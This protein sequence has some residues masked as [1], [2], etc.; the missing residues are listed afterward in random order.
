[1]EEP[2]ETTF[3]KVDNSAFYSTFVYPRLNVE[4][5]EIRLLR[6]D[7]HGLDKHELVSNISLHNP[8]AFSAL[9]YV[10]GPPTR[11]SQISVSGKLFN[12]F[13][14]L[15]AAIADA[16]TCWHRAFPGSELFLWT[17]QV[18]INQNDDNERSQQVSKMRDV[19]SNAEHTLIWLPASIDVEYEFQHWSDCKQ[20]LLQQRSKLHATS[21]FVRKTTAPSGSIQPEKPSSQSVKD[22]VMAV[23]EIYSLG[24][25]E[26][27][28]R[29]WVFQEFVVSESAMFMMKPFLVPW[30][31]VFEL[32]ELYYKS[33]DTFSQWRY[34]V[35]ERLNEEETGIRSHIVSKGLYPYCTSSCDFCYILYDM[36]T[37]YH[38]G[39]WDDTLNLPETY[40]DILTAFAG[41]YLGFI[42]VF[43]DK[44]TL[45]SRLPLS[46]VM[47]RSRN[48][49]TSEPR[50]KVY[51]YL[52]L[53]ADSNIITPNYRQR[54][55][56]VY[57]EVAR[58]IIEQDQ[59]LD[60][61]SQ[62]REAQRRSTHDDFLPSW[63]PTWAVLEDHRTTS[64]DRYFSIARFD[65]L[66]IFTD[67]RNAPAQ[68]QFLDDE[69][70]GMKNVI[71]QARG[72]MID[73]LVEKQPDPDQNIFYGMLQGLTMRVGASAVAGDSV[74]ALYGAQDFL[75]LRRIEGRSRV[76][77]EAMLAGDFLTKNKQVLESI[78]RASFQLENIRVE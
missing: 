8:P 14:N 42:S 41:H 78:E 24:R 57:T 19:Y 59:R 60:I 76:I 5:L 54:L 23:N 40:S 67:I 49:K 31:D 28:T 27:W 2:E 58:K 30:V 56:V 33:W 77:S 74:W 51:A 63:V 17:D 10:C 55:N 29:A 46:T 22:I 39:V 26:W 43:K 44:K 36:Y 12:A 75:V 11:T 52:G 64:K 15:A 4:L 70:T 68:Y 18:C 66:D 65:R 7:A 61:L 25:S 37:G 62:T 35:E 71:L 20:W 69:K 47:K 50:D 6:I 53:L 45:G 1:M 34:D 32:L 21:A 13:A 48:R 9:S 72:L 16:R 38:R 3:S 73:V